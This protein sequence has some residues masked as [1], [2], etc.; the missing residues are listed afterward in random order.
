MSEAGFFKIYAAIVRVLQGF[1]CLASLF[2]IVTNLIIAGAMFKSANDV[3][4]PIIYV[5]TYTIM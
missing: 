3:L 1:T 2:L 4:G 5:A